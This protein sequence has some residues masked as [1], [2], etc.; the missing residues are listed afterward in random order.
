MCF[1]PSLAFLGEQMNHV[2]FASG[3]RTEKEK[4][5]KTEVKVESLLL[6]IVF[7]SSFMGN[8]S[9]SLTTLFGRGGRFVGT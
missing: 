9:H 8:G 4:K 1:P 3:K 7:L 6:F 2:L 5:E